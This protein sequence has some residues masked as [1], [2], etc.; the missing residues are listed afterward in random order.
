LVTSAI[1]HLGHRALPA[2]GYGAIALTLVVGLLA[3]KRPPG[4]L[5]SIALLLTLLAG[6]LDPL[7]PSVIGTLGSASL[8]AFVAF[9]VATVLRPGGGAVQ[10]DEPDWTRRRLVA[11]GAL[12]V[13]M[14]G[15]LWT[16]GLRRA[17]RMA[18]ARIVRAAQP[19]TIPVDSN[20]VEIPG[21]S[22]RVT[23]RAD[24][25]LVD[26]DIEDPIVAESGWQLQVTGRVQSPL[27]MSLSDLEAAATV[28]RLFNLSCISNPVGGNLIGN[29]LWTGVP[30]DHLLDLAAPLPDARSLLVRAVDGYAEAIALDDI[31]GRDAIIAIAMDGETLPSSHGFPA[32]L[33]FPGHYGMR[34]VKWV[35]DL[36]LL[37]H[38]EQ[39][40]W[41]QRGWDKDAVVRT[42]SR[43]D[44]P[45]DG[46]GVT[47]PAVCAGIAWAGA[48]GVQGV[49]VSADNGQ[50]WQ[51]AQLE[52]VLAPLSWRR[53]RLS[54]ELPPGK[55]ALAVRA[56]DGT[57]RPQDLESRPPHPSG[58]SGYHRIGVTVRSG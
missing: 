10:R 45:G 58:A 26:I 5:A 51:P 22:P 48:R 32:R 36:V 25:Y 15:L 57:G 39:G 21:L 28:E 29:S 49:E 40:Y 1:D 52:A 2:L 6:W 55:H 38:D 50:S 30:L 18:P 24:H 31:R 46:D 19:A 4:V 3:G 27:S 23:P 16:A 33:L 53:W 20:F 34:N 12:G 37:D 9:L 11:S 41:A 43:F 8:A 14:L 47:S 17:L 7:R 54:L 13:V 56:T 35:T 44:V 42:E